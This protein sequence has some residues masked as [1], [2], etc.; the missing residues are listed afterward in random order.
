M[1]LTVPLVV[2]ATLL[3]PPIF[4]APA[5]TFISPEW[6]DVDKATHPDPNNQL[7]DAE[8]NIIPEPIRGNLGALII[9]PQNIPLELE[10]ADLFAPPTTDHGQVP[11]LKWP[12]A[13]SHNRLTKG[14]WARQQNG[15]PPVTLYI[16]KYLNDTA[17]SECDARRNCFGW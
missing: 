8:S 16:E 2:V 7:W 3:I 17:L 15:L 4:T 12:F 1:F 6:K 9:G 13:V 5:P 10:N 11:N 14:G